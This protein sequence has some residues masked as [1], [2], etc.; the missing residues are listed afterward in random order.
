MNK[1]PTLRRRANRAVAR[2][3]AVAATI[4]ALVATLGAGQALAGPDER[5]L[6]RQ[7][8]IDN[9]AAASQADKQGKAEE[10]SQGS[11]AQP[12]R[13]YFRPEPPMDTGPR[14]DAD[15]QLFPAPPPPPASDRTG[16]VI[17]LAVAALLLAAIAATTWRI[18]HRRPRPEPTS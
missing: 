1:Q 4:A 6:E 13:R 18:Y 14:L 17:S 15:E 10:P 2:T 7:G 16:L 8:M 3:L 12:P 11:P 9:Q 5:I